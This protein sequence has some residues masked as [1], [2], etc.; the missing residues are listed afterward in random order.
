MAF[1]SKA[2]SPAECNYE[3]YDKELLAIMEALED[4]QQYLVGSAEPFEILTD[5]LNLTYYRQPQKLSR[6]QANWVSG[7]Q[8]YSDSKNPTNVVDGLLF[9]IASKW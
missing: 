3:V 4:W 5:H 7:L 9:P 2:M 6:R 1:L 8:R